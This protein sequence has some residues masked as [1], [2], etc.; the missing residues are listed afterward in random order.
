MG[1]TIS[2]Q[3]NKG[4]ICSHKKSV[5]VHANQMDQQELRGPMLRTSIL[6]FEIFWF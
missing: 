2:S 4:V 1:A 3:E 5:F 6:T